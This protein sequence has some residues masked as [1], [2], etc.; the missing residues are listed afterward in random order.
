MMKLDPQQNLTPDC[1]VIIEING[2]GEQ[3]Q[4]I[5]SGWSGGYLDG[6][7]WRVSS[8]IKEMNLSI[9]EG[10]CTAE[11]LSGSTY[12]LHYDYQGLKMSNAGIY[13]ELKEK[14]G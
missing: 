1:W 2:E 3:F 6:L 9:E 4:K 13:N 14:Y 11:T 8:P 10:Y 12:I 5:L 7:M